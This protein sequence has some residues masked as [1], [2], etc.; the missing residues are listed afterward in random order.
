MN[1]TAQDKS[2]SLFIAKDGKSASYI[3]RGASRI[4]LYGGNYEIVA[5][6]GETINISRVKL[7]A[8][9]VKSVNIKNLIKY[10][11]PS[12]DLVDF[13]GINYLTDIG[14]SYPQTEKIKKYL[15]S[16]DKNSLSDQIYSSSVKAGPRSRDS[17][18]DFVGFNFLV[19]VGE[20]TYNAT[21]QRSL[22]NDDVS[23]KLYDKNNNLVF[24]SQSYYLNL[25]QG[26]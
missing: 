20:K 8:K 23:M 4:R 6:K 3:G 13:E 16:F 26:D 11:V 18:S 9:E 2:V 17:T 7:S 15:F 1:I 21:A 25:Q 10:R 12:I 14:V 24:D 22:F 19:S 5:V